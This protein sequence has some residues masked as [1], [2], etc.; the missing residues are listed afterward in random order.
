MKGGRVDNQHEA[1]AF[2]VQ[3]FT[4]L[5]WPIKFGSFLAQ[6]YTRC[7]VNCAELSLNTSGGRNN[8]K[9]MCRFYFEGIIYWNAELKMDEK[10]CGIEVDNRS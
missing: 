1:F 3:L 6:N 5:L 8:G 9:L 7:E 4:P 10:G 2:I